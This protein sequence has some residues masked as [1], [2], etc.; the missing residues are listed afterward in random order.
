MVWVK[1]QK[2]Q[3]R[4]EKQYYKM[5]M[6]LK[7]LE[8]IFNWYEMF[9]STGTEPSMPQF[10]NAMNEGTIYDCIS[11]YEAYKLHKDKDKTIEHVS[12][13]KCKNKYPFYMLR[14]DIE[15]RQKKNKISK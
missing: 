5:T 2:K 11:T 9:N 7:Y 12:E 1:K 13:L 14:Q 3:V 8:D 15:N 6:F 10:R 4:K